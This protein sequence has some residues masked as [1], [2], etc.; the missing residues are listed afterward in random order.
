M[1]EIKYYQKIPTLYTRDEKTKKLTTE[2]INPLVEYLKDCKWSFTEKID[3]T[4]TIVYW[5]GNSVSFHGR[6]KNADVQKFMTDKL[7]EMFGGEDNAQLFEQKFGNKQVYIYGELCGNKIGNNIYKKNVLDFIIFDVVING[8]Y[9]DRIDVEDISNYFNVPVVPVIMEGTLEQ[10]VEYVKQHNK[11]TLEGVDCYMEG[12]VGR[13]LQTILD[14][15]GNRVIVKIK[16][17]DFN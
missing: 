12:L 16:Y 5:D 14:K 4:N 1:N 6:T 10:V 17:R 7:Y 9:L 11:S 2:F 8:F 13:P 15:Q 3:G